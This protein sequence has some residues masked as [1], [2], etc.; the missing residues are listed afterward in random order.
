MTYLGEDLRHTDGLGDDARRPSVVAYRTSRSESE[1]STQRN[2]RAV[3]PNG[4]PVTMNTCVTHSSGTQTDFDSFGERRT[5]L[6]AHLV[7]LTN[8]GAC[9]GLFRVGEAEARDENAVDGEA[10]RRARLQRHE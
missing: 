1:A 8:N 6:D 7:K 2:G 9:F 10:E 5:H 3:A 4:L